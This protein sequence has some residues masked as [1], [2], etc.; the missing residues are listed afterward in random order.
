MSLIRARRLTSMSWQ[1]SLIKSGLRP[2]KDIKI[3]LTGV[4]QAETAGSA[5]KP[6]E[7]PKTVNGRILVLREDENPPM[8][9]EAEFDKLCQFIDNRDYGSAISR[10]RRSCPH[11]W[12]LKENGIPE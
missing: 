3:E 12:P 8:I 5:D 7:T 9:F 2:D 10:D 4:R 1:R 6:K 11:V